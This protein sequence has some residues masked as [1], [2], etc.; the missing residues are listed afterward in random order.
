MLRI[1]IVDD[2][3]NYR[4]AIRSILP[5]ETYGFTIA[6]EAVHGK[7]ALSLMESV[8][9][10]IVITDISMPMMN[11]IDLIREVKKRCPAVA[12]LALSSY[13]DFE[14][15]K[16]ALKQ[17][18][19]DYI[20]KHDMQPNDLLAVVESCA[21]QVRN[22]RSHPRLH[23]L[24]D[25]RQ[26]YV[27]GTLL[28]SYL[29]GEH[30]PEKD[31]IIQAYFQ[32]YHIYKNAPQVGL[33]AVGTSSDRQS[34]WLRGFID[35][36]C[37]LSIA[38]ETGDNITVFVIHLG[39]MPSRS[40]AGAHLAQLAQ[41]MQKQAL[42]TGLEAPSV[43]I[44]SICMGYSGLLNACM[45]ACAALERRVYDGDGKIFKHDELS[46]PN[47][48]L[49]VYAPYEALLRGIQTNDWQAI[50][51]KATR[52]WASVSTVQPDVTSLN[53]LLLT[54]C[55]AAETARLQGTSQSGV[56]SLR[57]GLSDRI[58][59]AKTLP[60]KK[61]I[62]DN[63]L[64]HLQR[65]AVTALR[66]SPKI[67]QALVFIEANFSMPITLRDIAVHVGLSPNYLSSVFKTET[68]QRIMNY[69]NIVRV[70]HAKRLILEGHLKVY[71][72]ADLT[73][74][75][76]ATYFSTTFK[77]VTG[78]TIQEFKSDPLGQKHVR[79]VKQEN[80]LADRCV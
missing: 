26:K 30:R 31:D 60:R 28:R 58:A 17:G 20:L 69:V 7:Q 49:L 16:E 11:G 6:A 5:W 70:Q 78:M 8:P 55:E 27:A 52:F 34:E 71:E 35:Q 46:W 4:Y 47:G 67:Q 68:G 64:S 76:S 21:K 61:E 24:S 44:S 73:G 65:P 51:D 42:Q 57:H 9:V 19:S 37:E 38:C 2:D 72:M 32:L 75:D 79:P 45:Q 77:K 56:T 53:S 13:D 80:S 41:R 1:M 12:I 22:A 36:A 62:L 29:L 66:Y 59:A 40:K 3:Q 15:V 14:Y 33:M 25:D 43:G 74:F 50:T 23:L 39:D 54:L 48:E 18:A 10:D 63:A